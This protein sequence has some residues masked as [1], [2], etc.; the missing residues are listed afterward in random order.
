[1]TPD[2]PCN[3]KSPCRYLRCYYAS[4]GIQMEYCL[5]SSVWMKALQ[6]QVTQELCKKP[7]V[8]RGHMSLAGGSVWFYHS[9]LHH[10]TH[11]EITIYV[12]MVLMNEGYDKNSYHFF[13]FSLQLF[14]SCVDA[15][16]AVSSIHWVYLHYFTAQ[17]FSFLFNSNIMWTESAGPIH[18]L[19]KV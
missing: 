19:E 9:S 4:Y 17:Y 12:L 14:V 11:I 3:C 10:T 16:A 2:N 1:M 5:S 7:N 15:A 8:I 6:I 13:Q 18:K